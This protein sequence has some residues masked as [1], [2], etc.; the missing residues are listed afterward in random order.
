MVTKISPQGLIASTR[1]DSTPPLIDLADCCGW[2]LL[3]DATPRRLHRE[4]SHHNPE[5][6]LFWLDDERCVTATA[7]LI[8]WSR[9]HGARPI[10]IVVA[11]EIDAHV[12]SVFRAAGAHGFFPVACH[13]MAFVT[14]ALMPMLRKSARGIHS[15]L[16]NLTPTASVG[17]RLSAIEFPSDLRRPP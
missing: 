15:N 8:A 7:T 2:P 14:D 6:V 16:R 12:E 9:E 13:S 5:C 3:L 17:I 10:R 1:S 4:L 11:F